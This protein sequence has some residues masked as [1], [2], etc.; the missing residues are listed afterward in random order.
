[1]EKAQSFRDARARTQML[2]LADEYERKAKEAASSE[3]VVDQC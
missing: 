1:M 2:K 3:I